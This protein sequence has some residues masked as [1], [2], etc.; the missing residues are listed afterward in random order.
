MFDKWLSRLHP[1]FMGFGDWLEVYL[2][3]LST[4]KTAYKADANRR[5]YI[6]YLRTHMGDMRLRAIRPVHVSRMH[7]A[8]WDL[9]MLHTAKRVLAEARSCFDEAINAGLIET[10]PAASVRPLPVRIKRARL[11]LDLWK[12]MRDMSEH[13]P[14][15]WLPSL[16][17]LALMTGQRRGDLAK[18]RFDD[19]WD[20]HLHIVQEK[21]GAR[22]ALPLALRLEAVGKSIGDVI[23]ACHDYQRQGQIFLLRKDNGAR[24]DVTT[25]SN[26]FRGCLMTTLGGRWGRDGNPPSLHECRSLSERLY[27]KQ[28]IDTMT[29][30]GHRRQSMTD[31]YNSPR[32]LSDDDWRTLRL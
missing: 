5:S 31:K 13:S 19:I 23:E 21:M 4:R 3:L 17:D 6:A 24:M 25:L 22:I 11:S 12:R 2:E 15:K 32:G 14:Q 27:R 20:D 26:R 1:A 10:N 16:L 28:G 18:M 30:L 9:G 29:L 8:I 7:R